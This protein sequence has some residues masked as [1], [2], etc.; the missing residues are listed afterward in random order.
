MPLPCPQVLSDLLDL[1]INTRGKTWGSTLGQV[2]S[3][4]QRFISFVGQYVGITKEDDATYKS[5]VCKI[6]KARFYVA[7]S[8]DDWLNIIN[9]LA[10]MAEQEQSY[11]NNESLAC[12]TFHAARS[13]IV[14]TL[15]SADDDHGKAFRAHRNHLIEQRDELIAEIEDKRINSNG[16]GVKPKKIEL[17]KLLIQLSYLGDQTS[18]FMANDFHL[19][20][21]LR[22]RDQID[23]QGSIFKNDINEEI[24]YCL[25][26]KFHKILYSEQYQQGASISF[27][28]FEIKSIESYKKLSAAEKEERLRQAEKDANLQ[29]KLTLVYSEADADPAPHSAPPQPSAASS[30]PIPP[31]PPPPPS[32]MASAPQKKMPSHKPQIQT[33]DEDEAPSSDIVPAKS[34]KLPE[35]AANPQRMDFFKQMALEAQQRK[36]KRDSRLFSPALEEKE[37]DQDLDEADIPEA[38]M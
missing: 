36:S 31:P 3:G 18:M 9:D 12:L 19:L 38:R 20:S 1:Y 29:Q 11:T 4:T 13:Y 25:Q 5:N 34:T 27:E 7:K 30:P 10:S 2:K 28:E 23:I 15:L 32:S 16:I 26:D 21:H 6:L 17:R 33:L 37:P 35:G 8:V 22:F 14:R 24:P